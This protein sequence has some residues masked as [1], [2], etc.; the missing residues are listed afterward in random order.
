[1]PGAVHVEQGQAVHADDLVASTNLPGNVTTVNVAGDLNVQPSEVPKAMVKAEGDSV[2]AGE[3]IAETKALWGLFHATAT[4]TVSGT[5]ENISSVTGQVLVRGEPIPV[6]LDAYI[7]GTVVEVLGEEGIIVQADCALVQGI[8]GFGGETHGELLLRATDPGDILDAQAIDEDCR[9]KVVVG[10][11]LVTLEALNR[12]VEVGAKGIVVG[13]IGHRDLD[14]FLGYPIG[15]AVTGGEQKGITVIITEGFGKIAMARRTFELLV[16]RDGAPASIN[17]ATQIRA[18]VI[19][20]EIIVAYA[21]DQQAPVAAG[22]QAHGMDIGSHIRLIRD[23]YFGMLGAIVELPEQ[24]Q[25]VESGATV[26]VLV[27]ELEDGRRV[28]VPRA[29]VELVEG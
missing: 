4:S 17:G 16:A 10:G 3:L 6:S 29:N 8:F 2:E 19:R 20:P 14:V 5:I 7:S 21:S 26:R 25:Q 1:M 18:G 28:S 12:A 22:V 15:V 9:G 27:A 24:P 11:S 23:P 13:G